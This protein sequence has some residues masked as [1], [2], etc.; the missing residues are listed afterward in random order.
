MARAIDGD[1][2]KRWCEKIIDQACHPATVQIGEVFLDKVRSMPTLTPPN[3]P[4]TLEAAK[5]AKPK[6]PA[7]AINPSR[8]RTRYDWEKAKTLYDQKWSDS[9]IA[10]AMGCDVNSVLAW[11]KREKLPPWPRSVQIVARKTAAI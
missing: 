9:K 8:R 5:R 2:L 7:I 10:T 3:E 11:R 4:L 1:A 6:G